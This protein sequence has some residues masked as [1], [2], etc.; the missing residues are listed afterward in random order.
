[1]RLLL[2]TCTFLWLNGDRSRVSQAVINLCSDPANELLLSAVSAWEIAV[3]YAA[4]R[5]TLPEPA[6]RYVLTRRQLNGITS[7]ELTEDDVLTI[8]KLPP[9][10]KDPF[11]RMLVCQATANDLAILTPD[12]HIARYPVRVIW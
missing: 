5:L 11:D 6:G 1:L 9:I 8:I 7:L 10:H 12:P 4:G 2:D 3:K